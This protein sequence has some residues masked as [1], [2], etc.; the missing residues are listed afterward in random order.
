M[1]K[2]NKAADIGRR[3]ERIAARFL[4][5]AG[6]R[7]VARNKRYGKHE[8]DLIVKDKDFLVFIEVK[9]RS[10]EG[11]LPPLHRP[12]DAVDL[13][14]RLHTAE[15]AKAYLRENYTELSP[16]FD[17]IEVYLDRAHRLRVARINHIRDAFSAS[18]RIRR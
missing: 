17:V 13:S 9:T 4:R 15:A 5:R 3:G 18:G 16:R 7:I 14:K 10:Y 8:L 11:N 6:Y 2:E 12:A 1:K